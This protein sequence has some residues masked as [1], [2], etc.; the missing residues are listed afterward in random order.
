[1]V[2]ARWQQ[3]LQ[4]L[5]VVPSA[6]T[7]PAGSSCRLRLRCKASGF[8]NFGT[9][10]YRWP[11]FVPDLHHLR[12]RGSHLQTGLGPRQV[13]SLRQ[14]PLLASCLWCS[15]DLQELVGPKTVDRHSVVLQPLTFA[16]SGLRPS[17]FTSVAALGFAL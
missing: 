16:A 3:Q 12:D 6:K 7:S 11:G 2:P 9:G 8:L 10:G 5:H 14:C 1:M 17:P 4:S 13:S 15:E